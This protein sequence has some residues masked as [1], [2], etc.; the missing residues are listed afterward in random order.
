MP[1]IRTKDKGDQVEQDDAPGPPGQP[2]SHH[3]PRRA[4]HPPHRPP[5]QRGRLLGIRDGGLAH[6]GRHRLPPA[7]LI[8]RLLRRRRLRGRE[9]G[10][11]GMGAGGPGGQ[12][13]KE[14]PSS[15]KRYDP[16]ARERGSCEKARAPWPGRA[17]K[18]R[19]E[20]LGRRSRRF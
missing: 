12:R 15:S 5:G 4:R 10:I 11:L 20:H 19:S 18:L 8:R 1:L 2:R 3:S 16:D 6:P 14:L 13:R 9:R 7:D 17:W